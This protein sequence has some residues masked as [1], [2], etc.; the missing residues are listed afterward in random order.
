MTWSRTSALE[1]ELVPLQQHQLMMCCG[2]GADV[3]S[4]WRQ[5]H[6]LDPCCCCCCRCFG[7]TDVIRVTEPGQHSQAVSATCWSPDE[8]GSD[9][10]QDERP[11]EGAGAPTAASADDVLRRWC[12][13]Q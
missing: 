13:C 12:G 11:G 9:L 1:K 5:Q 7:D 2:G 10:E 8:E 3:S 6:P 4:R